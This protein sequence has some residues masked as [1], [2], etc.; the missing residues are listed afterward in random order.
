M[1]QPAEQTAELHALT[2]DWF[3]HLSRSS[4][5]A[6]RL[7][8]D[9]AQQPFGDLRLPA[10]RLVGTLATAPWG[11]RLLIAHPGFLEYLLGM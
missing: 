1:C 6:V 10:L 2:E 5:N 9:I 8:L 3:S 7:V 11:E 4:D